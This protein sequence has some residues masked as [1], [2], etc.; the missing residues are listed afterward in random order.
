[1]LWNLHLWYVT[2]AKPN[3]RNS[4]QSEALCVTQ[5]SW[6]MLYCFVLIFVLH[7]ECLIIDAY[8]NSISFYYSVH[9]S[10]SCSYMLLF[11]LKHYLF[12]T[13]TKTLWIICI[14]SFQPRHG[15][16]W[17]YPAQ[18]TWII[19]AFQFLI[20][21]IRKSYLFYLEPLRICSEACSSCTNL[22]YSNKHW[23]LWDIFDIRIFLKG[24]INN[25]YLPKFSNIISIGSHG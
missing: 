6:E 12:I 18:S 3:S 23:Q 11:Q 15:C 14:P 2:G 22:T 1:M 8:F 9:I 10:I 5:H 7:L 19:R 4:V 24:A 25:I 16:Y 21:N 20:I 13:C 17:L